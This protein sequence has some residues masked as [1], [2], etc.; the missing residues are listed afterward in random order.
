VKRIFAMCAAVAI[1]SL[2]LTGVAHA[3]PPPGAAVATGNTPCAA[4][5]GFHSL[6]DH[7]AIHDVGSN[8]PLSNGRPGATSWMFPGDGGGTTGGNNNSICGGGNRP[9][10]FQ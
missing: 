1:A 6:G 3:G 2:W 4:H 8:N 5:G 7:G 10:P 9:P